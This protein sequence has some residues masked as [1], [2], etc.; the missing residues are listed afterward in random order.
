MHWE[1]FLTEQWLVFLFLVTVLN[2]TIVQVRSVTRAVTKNS[3]S[4]LA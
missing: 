4:K 3:H 2:V 1:L